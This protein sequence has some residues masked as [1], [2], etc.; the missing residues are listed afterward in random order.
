MAKENFGKAFADYD[1]CY[2]VL[3]GMVRFRCHKGCREGGGN[4]FC[5]IRK[6]VQRKKIDGCWECQDMET[7]SKLDFLT[8]VHDDA[9]LKN[10]R[11]IM[12]KGKEA[13]TNGKRYW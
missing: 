2:E 7:C 13:F 10:L 8:G 11:I 1:K 12:K 3:G 6:C 4:P 9:H 5:K